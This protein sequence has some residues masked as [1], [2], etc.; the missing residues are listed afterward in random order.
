[1]ALEVLFLQPKFRI[2]IFI[3]FCLL[4]T[5]RLFSQIS[6]E[7]VICRLLKLNQ[8]LNLIFILIPSTKIG[9]VRLRES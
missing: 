9:L 4:E 2:A 3:P 5:Y 8:L 6:L 7:H 1:M